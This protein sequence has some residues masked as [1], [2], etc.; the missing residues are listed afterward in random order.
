[1]ES[2]RNYVQSILIAILLALLVRSF[3]LAGYKVPTSSMAPNLIPGDFIFSFKLPFGVKVPLTD[4]HI[5]GSLPQR[6][7]IVVFT[8]PDQPKV[9]YV[10]RVIGLPGDR[11]QIQNGKIQLNGEYLKY[12]D[13]PG[14]NDL[15]GET[16]KLVEETAREGPRL[17]L[18]S[19][20]P[21][22]SQFGPLVVPPNEVFL[23]GDNRDSSDDSRYW[24]TVPSER[25]QGR[26]ILIWL[27]LDWQ[28][29]I[30]NNSMPQIRW[31][32]TWSLPN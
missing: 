24:G 5:S 27:S 31:Q 16:F 2:W 7:Q 9:T 32:R 6:G 26:V 11:I 28:N 14:S 13:L 20:M 8:Y 21:K 18:Y 23:L 12:Q 19:K 1:M 15:V 3:I 4:I 22:K 10:K 29:R 30:L 17:L 25:I